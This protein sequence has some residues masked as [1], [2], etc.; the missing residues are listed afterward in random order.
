MGRYRWSRRDRCIFH[1]GLV[2]V[3]WATHVLGM[4]ASDTEDILFSCQCPQYTMRSLQINHIL[5]TVLCQ[6]DSST[7]YTRDT[8]WPNG[9]VTGAHGTPMSSEHGNLKLQT[10]TCLHSGA[11]HKSQLREAS[12]CALA[13]LLPGA[14]LR[15]MRDGFRHK[16]HK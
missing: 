3:Q 1:V 9:L 14:R 11:A 12:F 15:L 4:T 8:C 13:D 5:L 2:P 16:S 7:N 10:Q 6:V